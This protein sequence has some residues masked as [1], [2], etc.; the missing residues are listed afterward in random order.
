LLLPGKVGRRRGLPEISRSR[1]RATVSRLNPLKWHSTDLSVLFVYRFCGLGGVETSLTTKL[2]ALGKFRVSARALLLEHYGVGSEEIARFPGVLFGLET[3]AIQKLLREVEIIVVT[4]FP[5]FFDLI[6]ESGS[7]ASVVFESHASYLPALERFYSRLGSSS[8]SAIV[9]PSE[10]NRGLI[11]RFGVPHAPIHMIPN[12][13]DTRRFRREDV[14]PNYLAPLGSSDCPLIVWVG[15]LEDQKSPFEFVRIGVRLLRERR[16]MQFAL[17]GDTPEYDEA[18]AQ[19]RREI[20][21]EFQRSFFFLRGIP[22]SEMPSIYN[23][24]RVTGGCVVSTSLNE[25]QPM[26]LLEAMACGCPVVSS[27]VGGVPEI[28][29]DAVTGYLYD[30][31]DDETAGRAI[32]ALADPGSRQARDAMTYRALAAV[33]ERHSPSSVGARYR[34][35]FDSIR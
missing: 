32:I 4:D 2:K 31:G 3:P 33:R 27:R 18:V 14:S 35:L 26:V 1:I 13:V 8:I 7:S 19:L 15:R 29:E 10:F 20:L 16:K 21:P 12:A 17:V 28:V 25:S 23:A 5:E 34:K 30:L 22:P 9:V 6:L 11:S 24:A